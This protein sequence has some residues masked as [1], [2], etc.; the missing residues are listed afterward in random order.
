[1]LQLPA[2]PIA[3]Q[4]LGVLTLLVL[5]SGCDRF[6]TD[7]HNSLAATVERGTLRVGVIAN[8]PWVEMSNP[9]APAGLESDLVADYAEQLGVDVE[10][11][12]NGVEQQIEAL[13]HYQL[14]LLIG[15]FSAAHPWQAEVGQ[16]FTYFNERSVGGARG[17]HVIL[18]APG[19]NALLISLE[20][21]LFS[22]QNPDRYI[23]HLQKAAQP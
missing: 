4:L 15:G 10:W 22:R 13:T 23:P 21:F 5:T 19:E 6:P 18:T 8:P 17:K 7:P 1:M 12:T 9:A 2:F 3:V 20:R 16:T 14:D 11:H